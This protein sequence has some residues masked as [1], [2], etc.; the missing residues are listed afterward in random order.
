MLTR[1][2][3]LGLQAKEKEYMRQCKNLKIKSF[4]ILYT[5]MQRSWLISFASC[6]LRSNIVSSAWCISIKLCPFFDNYVKIYYFWRDPHREY[7]NHPLPPEKNQIFLMLDE[8]HGL[9][10]FWH[11]DNCI[12]NIRVY[13]SVK[14]R[15]QLF[16]EWRTARIG[17]WASV[18]YHLSPGALADSR[19]GLRAERAG[20]I[21]DSFA[22][23]GAEII[24][25]GISSG[26]P[27]ETPP[28]PLCFGTLK[29]CIIGIMVN[30]K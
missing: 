9:M 30:L 20:W 19:R 25:E 6:C 26:G 5:K 23:L 22:E 16:R 24:I 11:G 10:A 3:A 12:F 15:E 29:G 1:G 13:T 17:R 27:D 21:F 18:W 14:G 7:F 8:D 4:W 2:W 28:H